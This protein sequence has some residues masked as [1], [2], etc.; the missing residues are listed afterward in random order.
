[1]HGWKSCG[2]VFLGAALVAGLPGCG[3]SG[4]V[5]QTCPA[6]TT[7]TPPNCAAPCTQS[8]ILQG[9]A[10]LPANTADFETLTTTT[11]G[12]VDVS[13]DW[14]F[15]SSQMGVFVAMKPC[16]FDQFKA[17]NC[18]FLLQLASP[19]KP[20]KASIPNVAPGTY[21]L[22]IANASSDQES[23]SASVVLSSATC[24]AVSFTS[25]SAAT[26]DEFFLGILRG[27]TG[28]LGLPR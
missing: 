26:D 15:P 14:T 24:P 10:S 12:R 6:G 1:M 17:G 28:S 9:N 5:T 27:F 20:L 2:L 22:I 16:E 13:L 21:E 7:G 19:P 3:G 4:S 18:Q 25:K 11:T 8:P 23:V